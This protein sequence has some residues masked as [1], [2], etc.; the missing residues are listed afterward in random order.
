V[1]SFPWLAGIAKNYESY[2]F[3]RL[4]VYYKSEASS[5]LGG[6]AFLTIDYDAVDAAPATKAIALSYR[7]AVRSS[8]WNNCELICETKDLHKNKSNFVRAGSQPSGTDLKTYDIANLYFGSESVAGSGVTLGEIWVEYDVSLFT[9]SHAPTEQLV[10]NGGYITYSDGGL[11]PLNPFGTSAA[12]DIQASGFHYDSKLM[13]VYFDAPGWYMFVAVVGGTGMTGSNCSVNPNI[14]TIHTFIQ[15]TTTS[16]KDMW[17]FE[18]LA[19]AA[20]DWFVIG[21][22]VTSCY[23]NIGS[24]PPFSNGP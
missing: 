13:Q 17:V 20:I 15:T 12:V 5:S 7:S 21:S 24:I 10:I 4:A 8:P 9:P 11:T 14:T 23:A 18:V 16:M 3:N 1:S 6:S 19:P 2:I 22:T